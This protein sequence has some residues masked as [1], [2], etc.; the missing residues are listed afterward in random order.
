VNLSGVCEF[1]KCG[2]GFVGWTGPEDDIRE[3]LPIRNE[4]GFMP[5]EAG[6]ASAEFN[7]GHVASFGHHL[8]DLI[9]HIHHVAL[10]VGHGSGSSPTVSN[11]SPHIEQSIFSTFWPV[12]KRNHTS[13]QSGQSI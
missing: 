8:Q 4:E 2:C 7:E 5:I 6:N 12:D 13:P 3:V 1:A 10:N 11:R 9:G